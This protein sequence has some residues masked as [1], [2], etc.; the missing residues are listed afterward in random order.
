[1]QGCTGRKGAI[2]LR[3][4]RGNTVRRG[5]SDWGNQAHVFDVDMEKIRLRARGLAEKEGDGPDLDAPD[6]RTGKGVECPVEWLEALVDPRLLR[7]ERNSEVD[8]T[9]GI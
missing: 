8:R 9:S 1:M 4:S 3:A 5:P 2:R 7:D 6:R